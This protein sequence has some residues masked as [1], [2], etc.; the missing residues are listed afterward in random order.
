MSSKKN[1][2]DFTLASLKKGDQQVFEKLYTEFYTKLYT[3]ALNYISDIETIEDIVQDTFI[4]LWI[5]RKKLNI[6]TSL[7][8]YLYRI[9]YHKLMDYYRY[10]KKKDMMLMTYKHKALTNVMDNFNNNEA[11]L[12]ERLQK[13]ESCIET[14]P[15]RCKEVFIAKKITN[16]K[17]TEVSEQ[18][19]ISIKTVEGH[20]TRAFTLI[21]D[22]MKPIR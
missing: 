20:V 10:T 4:G 18:F 3:Y 22:C 16:L 19:K 9:V 5:N 2:L 13:L 12:T 21:K 11:Y 14:L 1:T 15:D 8:S 6:T 17:Y 7:K